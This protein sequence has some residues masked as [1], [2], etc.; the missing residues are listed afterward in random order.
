MQADGLIIKKHA[1][2]RP[3]P[4]FFLFQMVTRIQRAL[5]PRLR[6]L[7]AQIL[8]IFVELPNF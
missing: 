4:R 2:S 7:F 8:I 3:A 5:A 6:K 1:D